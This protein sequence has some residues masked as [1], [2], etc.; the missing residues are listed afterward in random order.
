MA[1]LAAFASLPIAEARPG[2]G[3]VLAE[4]SRAAGLVLIRN[5]DPSRSG[6]N[7][8][9]AKRDLAHPSKK[10]KIKRTGKQHPAQARRSRP[11]GAM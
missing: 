7:K 6:R 11:R 8:L 10:E 3:P 9:R 1:L 5:A 4:D 2:A